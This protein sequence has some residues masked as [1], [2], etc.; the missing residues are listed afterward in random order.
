MNLAELTLVTRE[1]EVKELR[2][3]YL[4]RIKEV[5]AMAKRYE[6]RIEFLE[7]IIPKLPFEPPRKAGRRSQDE[8]N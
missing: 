6:N 1:A 5:E 3:V 8:D 7:E 4:N 2:E